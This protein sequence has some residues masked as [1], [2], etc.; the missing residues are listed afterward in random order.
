MDVIEK[1]IL[2]KVERNLDILLKDPHFK[3]EKVEDEDCELL[4]F[5]LAANREAREA[6]RKLKKIP[7]FFIWLWHSIDNPTDNKIWNILRNLPDDLIKRDYDLQK[8]RQRYKKNI[9]ILDSAFSLKIYKMPA[10]KDLMRGNWFPQWYKEYHKPH[11]FELIKAGLK[12]NQ[13]KR[14]ISDFI[15]KNPGKSSRDV[16]RKFTM[17]KSELEDMLS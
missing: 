15:Q 10:V 4:Y 16:Q 2:T 14:E 12:K 13:R 9:P 3:I 6:G 7:F 17:K 8:I 11:A 1:K 5:Y